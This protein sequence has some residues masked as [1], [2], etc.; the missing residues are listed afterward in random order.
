MKKSKLKFV[1]AIIIYFIFMGYMIIY[2]QKKDAESVKFLHSSDNTYSNEYYLNNKYTNNSSFSKEALTD[3]EAENLR[4]TGYQN[5]RPYSSAE[6][7][8]IQAA[9]VKCKECGKHSDNGLNSLCDSCQRKNN[10]D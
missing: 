8:E 7:I 2:N 9:Q 1:F 4:G 3:E 6:N 5:T 10:G